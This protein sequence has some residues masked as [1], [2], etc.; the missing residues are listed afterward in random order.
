MKLLLALETVMSRA[1]RPLWLNGVLAAAVIFAVAA[2]S[3]GAGLSLAGT[4]L[5][6]IALLPL[7]LGVFGLVDSVRQEIR[8][9]A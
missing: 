7:G 3:T 4:V 9:N 6:W 2:I 8:A 5:T 1:D